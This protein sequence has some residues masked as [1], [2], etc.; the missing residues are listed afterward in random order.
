MDES[1]CHEK[2]CADLFELRDKLQYLEVKI[3]NYASLLTVDRLQ[4]IA[5]APEPSSSYRKAMRTLC[6][7]LKSMT[8]SQGVRQIKTEETFCRWDKIQQ[9]LR[10]EQ[11]SKQV[12]MLKCIE[13]SVVHSQILRQPLEQM[14]AAVFPYTAG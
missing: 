11:A 14:R 3:K 1:L 2:S 4:H 8:S 13:I 7:L 10:S 9:Y 12:E 6:L 5:A